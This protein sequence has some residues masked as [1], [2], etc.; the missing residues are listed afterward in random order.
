MKRKTSVLLAMAVAM[1]MAATSCD[2]FLPW[3][4]KPTEFLNEESLGKRMQMPAPSDSWG[5]YYAL[6]YRMRDASELIMRRETYIDARGYK[7]GGEITKMVSELKTVLYADYVVES[8]YMIDG[9]VVDIQTVSMVQENGEKKLLEQRKDASGNV[10]YEFDWSWTEDRTEYYYPYLIE[11]SEFS[12]YFGGHNNCTYYEKGD[13][14]SAY[15]MEARNVYTESF[16]EPDGPVHFYEESEYLVQLKV[17]DSVDRFEKKYTHQVYYIEQDS[18]GN[19]IDSYAYAEIIK[20]F[21]A[22][23]GTKKMYN[24]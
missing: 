5:L 11:Y 3:T 2:L 10:Y 15:A 16:K 20:E 12:M 23:Y 19:D 4:Y 18:E 6:T 7:E 1:C 9:I 22:V 14:H 17:N 21:T 24:K 8:T 13:V